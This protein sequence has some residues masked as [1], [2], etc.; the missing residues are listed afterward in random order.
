MKLSTMQQ[1]VY[2]AF[3]RRGYDIDIGIVTLFALAYP[4]QT[5]AGWKPRDMQQRLAPLFWRINEKL[6]A[7]RIEPGKLKQTYRLTRKG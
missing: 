2:D 4:G 3:A 7:G 5:L 6:S 1:R